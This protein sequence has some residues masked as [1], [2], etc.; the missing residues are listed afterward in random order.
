MCFCLCCSYVVHTYAASTIERML[1]VRTDTSNKRGVP[2]TIQPAD[3]APMLTP[4]LGCL[5]DILLRENYP[6]NEYIVRC[7]CRVVY[8]AKDQALGI[9]KPV[10]D[11]LTAVLAKIS[12]DPRA[13]S[14][15][16]YVFECLA[17]LVRNVCG[18]NA[19]AVATFEAVLFPIFNVRR[20][21]SRCS[22]RPQVARHTVSPTSTLFDPRFAVA[23]PGHVL[24]V[25]E[26]PSR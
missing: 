18:A 4:L 10:L 23:V 9:A 12:K 25:P 3:L 14:Y 13:P 26:N 22:R 20:V 19:S 6:E 16:H 2:L 17:A 8:S 7:L 15:N 11:K 24:P 1:T 5:F 21:H